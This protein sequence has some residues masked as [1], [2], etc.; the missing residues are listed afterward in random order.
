M[1]KMNLGLVSI[2][3]PM[4]NSGMF[5]SQAVESVIAQTYSNWELL[6]VDD[7][8]TDNSIDVVMSYV[9]R[10]SR[11]HLLINDNHVGMPYAPRNYGIGHAKGDYIAFLDSDDMWL[12]NKLS[13]QLPLFDERRVAVVF[14][15][16]EKMDEAGNREGRCVR[17]PRIVNYSK[18][19]Y[20][21]V[22]GNLTGIF[23][24]KKVGKVYF[25][26]IH[27]EDYAFWLS[28]LKKG[29]VARSTQSVLALYRVREESVSS[30][31]L[32]VASWQWS[33]YRDIE[34]IGFFRSS[35]YFLVYAYKAFQK[36]LI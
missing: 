6:V 21:N 11:I 28:V 3:M 9:E 2:I 24:V 32:T 34:H 30:R 4:H 31:K 14:S 18:L 19:L 33:I 12:P 10:D 27:H 20:S 17:T 23:D 29:Y 1:H 35:C 26:S 5:V 15:N 22:I 7:A 16:Y 36:M 25:Q 8:S 13:E